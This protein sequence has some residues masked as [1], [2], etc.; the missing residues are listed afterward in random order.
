MTLINYNHLGD[1]NKKLREAIRKTKDYA[2]KFGMELGPEEVYERLVSDRVWPREMV[3][4]MAGKTRSKKN[5]WVKEKLKRAKKIAEVLMTVEDVLLVGVTGSVA[6]GGAKKD[7]DID[8]LVICKKDSLWQT[9]WKLWKK[10]RKARVLLRRAGE[11]KVKDS[12]CF[13]MWLEEGSLRLPEE[14]QSLRSAVDLVLMKVVKE[15]NDIYKKFLEENDWAEKWVAT[16][17]FNLIDKKERNKRKEKKEENLVKKL[18]NIIYFWGQL[19]YMRSKMTE[20]KV[21]L[22]QAFFHKKRRGLIE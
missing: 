3:E 22:R 15:K 2:A 19:I 6:A 5:K 12:F 4:A 9:R 1:G 14:K 13:N 11:K 16:A 21:S 18:I 17:Y 10:L 20:E 8:M 7:D